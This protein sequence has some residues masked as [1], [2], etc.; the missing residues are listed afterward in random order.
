MKRSNLNRR[1]L[2]N[3]IRFRKPY[4]AE[5]FEVTSFDLK[6]R[7]DSYSLRKIK[8]IELRELSLKDNLL[9]SLSLALVLSAATWAFVPP[10]GFVI[11]FICLPF[12][13]LTYRK[14]ELRAEFRATDETG[15]QWVPIARCCTE[16]EFIVLNAL[17]LELEG[18]L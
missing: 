4:V 3:V 18:K 6:V 16:E 5:D 7:K 13:F 1:T 2:M 8:K 10:A 11:F 17:Q 12:V 9:R 15:D 14:Y